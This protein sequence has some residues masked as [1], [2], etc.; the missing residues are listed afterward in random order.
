MVDMDYLNVDIIKVDCPCGSDTG[1]VRVIIHYIDRDQG[2]VAASAGVWC[3][4]CHDCI[5]KLHIIDP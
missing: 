3:P 2:S 4:K 1:L 5:E